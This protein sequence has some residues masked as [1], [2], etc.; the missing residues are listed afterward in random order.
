MSQR[1]SLTQTSQC[2]PRALTSDT[3]K[4]SNA[5]TERLE[6]LEREKEHVLNNSEEAKPDPV[7]IHSNALDLYI[8]RVGNLRQEFNKK[9]N[10]SEAAQILRSLIEEAS[11]HPINEEL[12]IE[13]IEGLVRQIG[14]ASDPAIQK[15]GVGINPGSTKLLVV[16][17]RSPLFRTQISAYLPIR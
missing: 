16:G 3:S 5:L 7:C 4:T 8:V 17:T 12:Q 2:V 10:R 14:F 9:G 11:I 13:F 1:S 15:P 6:R